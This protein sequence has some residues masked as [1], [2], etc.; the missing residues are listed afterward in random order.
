MLGAP[1]DEHLPMDPGNRSPRCHGRRRTVGGRSGAGAAQGHHLAPRA[2][3]DLGGADGLRRKHLVG[4][5]W[6]HG[7]SVFTLVTLVTGVGFA[8][9]HQVQ[10]HRR[11]MIALYIGALVITGLFT[12]LPG[13]LIGSALWGLWH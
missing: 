3:L 8:R 9:A 2:R 6:I 5:S 10:A 11:N 12:L 4:F 7:L 1:F 13:R